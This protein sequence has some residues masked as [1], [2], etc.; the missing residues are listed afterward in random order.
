MTMVGLYNHNK[1]NQVPL[2]P[3]RGIYTIRNPILNALFLVID[4]LLWFVLDNKFNARFISRPQKILL[5]NIAHLGDVVVATSVLPVLKSA[6][7]DAEI[8]FL[9][10]S[11]SQV[12]VHD[13][14][15]I[16]WVHSFDH[17]MHNR[18]AMPFWR[19][20]LQHIQTRSKA[21]KE[22]NRWL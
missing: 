2:L 4:K 15:M 11:W 13:H 21:L 8:G 22:S 17:V 1:Y 16:K 9:V 20:M 12:V 19:K 7:P 10:G 14:P 3:L 6:F 5:T 18:V